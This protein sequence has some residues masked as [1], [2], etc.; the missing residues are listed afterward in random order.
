[1]KK[2]NFSG[3]TLEEA[4]LSALENLKC[5]EE[6]IYINEKETKGGLFKAK[7]VE[8]EVITKEEIL[9]EIKRELTNI[10]NLMGI[11]G[12]F[13][14]KQRDG[15]TTI[16]IFSDNNNILIGKQGRTIEALSL[17]LK[18]YLYNELGFYFPFTLDV[19]EYKL[20]HQHQLERLAKSIARDVKRT[21]MDVKLDYY[22]NTLSEDY[23]LT[24]E[25]AKEKYQSEIEVEEARVKVN[26]YKNNIKKIGMVN[27][28]SI[29]EYDKIYFLGYKTIFNIF[30]TAIADSINNVL[31]SSICLALVTTNEEEI[32]YG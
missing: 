7:K 18:Q 31:A 25:K 6:D 3:K 29:E 14:I 11:K 28:A 10:I 9:E 12:N 27:L 24:F 26:T 21:K 32:Y 15:M 2:N 13:E 20:K 19:G 1:M 17:I 22:L 8:I 5:N 16:T 30:R 23:E 4:K